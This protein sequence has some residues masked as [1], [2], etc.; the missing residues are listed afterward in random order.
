MIAPSAPPV[1]CPT[2]PRHI[3]P[4]AA[5]S[6]LGCS[7]RFYFERVLELPSPTSP[8]LHLG[9]AVHAALQ[10]FHLAL[11]RGEDHTS[12]DA[13]D[14]FAEAFE[15]LERDEG[16]VGWRT[17]DDREKNRLAGLR[18]LAAYLDSD[19]VLSDR[20]TGVEVSLVEEIE[21]LPVL[22]TGTIDLVTKDLVAIDF[23]SSAS[24][25][26][27]TTAAFDHELQLVCYQLLIEQACGRSPKSLDL[28]YLVKTKVPKVLR[29]CSP[30]ADPMRKRRAVRMLRTAVEGIAEGRHHPQPGM[31]CSWCP[32]RRECSAWPSQPER[33]AS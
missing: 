27:P 26:D 30:P 14:F 31:H 6:Y 7:L 23:K 22:L 21:G 33:R 32:Y 10:R 3:S 13:A 24:T 2:L 9:K 16:P 4:S 12:A 11:W 5:K 15:Q 29:V 25:P 20:P 18:V 17:P 28:V 1:P 19:E 8:A